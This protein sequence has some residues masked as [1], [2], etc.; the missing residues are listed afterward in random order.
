MTK[1]NLYDNVLALHADGEFYPAAIT[2]FED[3]KAWVV[4]QHESHYATSALVATKNLRP[5]TL[6]VGDVIFAPADDKMFFFPAT[7]KSI[8]GANATVQSAN[9]D[10]STRKLADLAF[11]LPIAAKD[12]LRTL[13]KLEAI[14]DVLG[15]V[16]EEPKPA[17]LRLVSS[18]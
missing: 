4:W 16:A 3:G 1:F 10:V 8:R 14:R 12:L 15:P 11:T 17:K 5:Y 7:I 18:R 9:G 6:A 13:T 2:L